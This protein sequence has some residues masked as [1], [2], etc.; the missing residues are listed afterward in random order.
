MRHLLIVAVL[1]LV[2][3]FALCAFTVS[4]TEFAAK[5]RLGQITKTDF[6]PGLKWKLPWEN[7]VK[8][9]RR[10]LTLDAQP[11][12]F[13]TAEKKDV[14][15]DSFVKWRINDVRDFYTA[16]GGD[17]LQA[18]TRLNAIIAD[19]LRAQFAKRTL[20]QVVSTERDQI[21]KAIREDADRVA[22]SLGITVVDVRVKKIDLPPEVSSSVFRRMEAERARTARELRAQGQE[23]SERIQAD[24]DRQVKVLLAEAERDSSRTRGAG[25]AEAAGLYAQAYDVDREF[26][27]FYRSLEAYR[28][29]FKGASDVM[30][31]DAESQ[32]FNYFDQ[33]SSADN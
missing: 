26:Y 33:P 12:R 13:I 24:A 4:E 6:E 2:L 17:E 16:T 5:F 14:I 25:E 15:V 1:A 9:D 27:S 21:M 8:F 7:V 22:G 18:R 29:T 31:L 23:Q 20:Q 3:F 11:E 32:F 10:I 28:N 19:G 30:L